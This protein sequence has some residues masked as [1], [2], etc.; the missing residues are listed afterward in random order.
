[1][2]H[3]TEY[4]HA[5]PDSIGGIDG[6]NANA[7]A[8]YWQNPHG[9]KIIVLELIIDVTTAG[10]TAGSVLDA[11][12]AASAATHSDNMINDLNLNATAL[13]YLLPRRNLMRTGGRRIT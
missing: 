12:S 7:F 13:L 2:G 5:I 11:G 1:M 6:R 3:A 4:R 10:G 8:F 9:R